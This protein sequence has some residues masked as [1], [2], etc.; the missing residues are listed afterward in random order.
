MKF[1]RP[2]HGISAKAVQNI[3][4]KAEEFLLLLKRL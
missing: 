1:N 4:V 2:K 3:N